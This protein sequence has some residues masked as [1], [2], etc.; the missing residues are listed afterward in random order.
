MTFSTECDAVREYESLARVFVKSSFVVCV[1]ASV[2]AAFLAPI[3]VFVV[4]SVF[5][6]LINWCFTPHLVNEAFHGVFGDCFVG[7][8]N[9]FC[10]KL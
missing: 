10:Y 5:P 7:V 8:I 1:V 9:H 4:N 6:A 2:A 3:T